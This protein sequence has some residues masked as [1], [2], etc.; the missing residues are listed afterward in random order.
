MRGE[1]SVA[2]AFHDLLLAAADIRGQ[3]RLSKEGSSSRFRSA[4]GTMLA[5]S[6]EIEREV[7][8][9]A[10]PRRLLLGANFALALAMP[11]H[12]AEL[13]PAALV[14]QFPD[15]ISWSSPSAAGSQNAVLVGDPSQPSLYV[16]RNTLLKGHHFT[17]PHFHPNDR[18]TTTL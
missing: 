13:N 18:F 6:G 17:P 15:Q 5:I 10:H 16:V 4:V 14:Y 7:Q 2:A 8:M 9:S 12:A 3:S 11:S 1:N